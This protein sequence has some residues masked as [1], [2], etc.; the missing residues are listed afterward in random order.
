MGRTKKLTDFKP[1]KSITYHQELHHTCMNTQICKKQISPSEQCEG[2][3]F[4]K[5]QKVDVAD[6][7]IRHSIDWGF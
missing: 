5:F 1:L 2:C 3:N 4:Y 6:N 7:P